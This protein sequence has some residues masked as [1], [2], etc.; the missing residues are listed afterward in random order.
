LKKSIPALLSLVALC[1]A[2]PTVGQGGAKSSTPPV[3]VMESRQG[4]HPDGPDFI[5]HAPIHKGTKLK[6]IMVEIYDES[7]LA[8][9][10]CVIRFAD[11]SKYTLSHGQS[12]EAP[13]EGE[14]YL[15]C[16]GAKPRRCRVGVF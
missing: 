7:H 9:T 5:D 2:A 13:V 11:G 6:C 16:S 4:H 14:S 3:S 8:Y 1:R 10:S 12:M 15:E